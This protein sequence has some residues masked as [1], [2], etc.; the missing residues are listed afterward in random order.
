MIPIEALPIEV[1][2]QDAVERCYAPAIEEVVEAACAGQSVLVEC[3]KLLVPFL[4]RAVCSA[5]A[6]RPEAP[7]LVQVDHRRDTGEGPVAANARAL[8][9]AVAALSETVNEE[10]PRGRLVAVPY[11][12][13][14]VSADLT[15]NHVDRTAREVVAIAYQN[16]DLRLLAFA[17]PA[18][19]VPT[20]L[21]ELFARR[22]DV[23]GVPRSELRHVI[24]RREARRIDTAGFDPYALY[25]YVSG[26]NVVTLR[27]LLCGLSSSRYTDGCP[28]RVIRDLRRATSAEAGV[29]LADTPMSSIGGYEHVKKRLTEDL[30]ELMTALDRDASELPEATLR[31]R[32]RLLSR[33]VLMT[34]PPGTGK[35]LFARALAT[36][37]D[38][39]VLVVNGP[40]LKSRWV[41]EGEER[42]RKLFARARLAA[43]AVIVFDEIDAFGR[44]RSAGANAASSPEQAGA[45]ATSSEHSM[46]VQ[47]LAEMEGFSRAEERVFVVATTNFP[48]T[49]DPALRRRFGTE[50]EVGYPN[51]ADREAILRV[52]DE[53]FAL[54]LSA[55]VLDALVDETEAWIEQRTWTRF[56]GSDLEGIAAALGRERLRAKATPSVTVESARRVA[57]SRIRSAE[58]RVTFADIGGYP[59]IKARLHRDL[60]DL[61]AGVRRGDDP[62][63]VTE[64]LPRGVVLEGPPG[65][66]KTL[67]ARALAEA[68]GATISIVSGPELMSAWHG[69][70]ERRIRELFAQARKNAPAV[71]VFDEIDSLAGRRD[72]ARPGVS[73]SMVNQLLAE[74][75]GFRAREEVY[76]IATTNFAAALDSAFRRP[77]RFELVLEVP[78]PDDSDRAEI[79]ALYDRRFRLGLG[80]DGV[81][82]L[83]RRTGGAVNPSMGTRYSGDH[84]QAICR[85]IARAKLRD[86]TWAPTPAALDAAVSERTAA[87]VQVTAEEERVVATHEA[88]HALVAMVLP[89]C[90]PIR[91][92][93]I[94]S[95]FEGALGYVQHGRPEHEYVQTATELQ[96]ALVCLMGGRAAERV[97]IGRMATGGASDVER[98]TRIATHLVCTLGMDEEIGPR[99]V[100]HPL[101]HGDR[102]R[103]ATSA[104]L[105]QRVEERVGALLGDAQSE[106]E[107]LLREHRPRLEALRDRLLREKTILF[108]DEGLLA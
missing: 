88:G 93:S 1:G 96:A 79:L 55:E 13:V 70:T 85:S 14:M 37:L 20:V 97:L 19:T 41:G 106:A 60:L 69:E 36:A 78:Y 57:R 54:E 83:V 25:K 5:L 43:P 48:E 53:S 72:H 38:A 3:Q 61:R 10:D 50:V 46:L 59:A 44:A 51:R 82:H 42:I 86:A 39:T 30:L 16:P 2:T 66:G 103:G 63:G 40:E 9:D 58:R 34:G 49:L 75:D 7:T 76:V 8:R 74:M 11:F 89:G 31:A 64:M 27:R 26:L 32:E 100:L 4:M 56:A 71:V 33:H 77:G 80:D 105:L 45:V 18:L 73:R 95:E 47:L 35:T 15:G 6:S 99:L 101:I 28:E 98:A 102:A 22:I 108:D 107:G 94:A 23:C 92:I 52:Y 17:D 90:P 104:A 91:K 21:R 62:R 24:S 68:L 65:T 67:F 29:E 81:A 87:P 12:D 84:L